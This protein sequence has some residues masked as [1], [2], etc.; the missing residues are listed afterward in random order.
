MQLKTYTNN[1][2][3]ALLGIDVSKMKL[4]QIKELKNYLVK[5][6]QFQAAAEL[7]D[8]EREYIKNIVLTEDDIEAAWNAARITL[9]NNDE[10]SVRKAFRNWLYTHLTET[11]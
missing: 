8:I 4:K 7:R 2:M 6:Q 5:S 11:K 3:S 10:E 9:T 1:N